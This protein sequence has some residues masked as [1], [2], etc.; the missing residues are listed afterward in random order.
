MV[1]AGGQV[2]I[3]WKESAPD[4]E[5]RAQVPL[6]ADAVIDT[7]FDAAVRAHWP[8]LLKGDEVRLPFLVPGRQ[9]FYPVSVRRTGALTWQGA[10]AQS[11]EVRL[12][13]W[14]GAITPRLSLVYADDDR[15][16][17]EFRGPSN[18]RDAPWRVSRRHC[19][20]R[21]THYDAAPV[22]L[23]AGLG[24]TAGGVLRREQQVKS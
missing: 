1:V 18:L 21:L 12:A 15:R 23:A 8:A 24:R 13:T 7:G 17:L 19:P 16:L 14:Y 11:I 3:D 22:A 6:P 2:S 4:A 20:L 9:R 10:P 5:R